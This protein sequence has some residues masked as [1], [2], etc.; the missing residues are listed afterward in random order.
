MPISLHFS[1][2]IFPKLLF[3]A[4]PGNSTVVVCTA[5]VV[6]TELHVVKGET[7]VVDGL[8]VIAVVIAIAAPVV[9]GW[10]MIVGGIKISVEV[11]VV[12]LADMNVVVG[13]VTDDV[14]GSVVIGV[15]TEK[16]IE[17]QL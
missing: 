7:T 2:I 14:G 15:F 10:V 16:S 13:I 9:A 6:A 1:E 8:Y 3:S 17:N 5:D 11:A 12:V 4:P